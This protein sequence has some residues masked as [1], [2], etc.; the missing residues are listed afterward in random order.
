MSNVWNFPD[1]DYLE[2]YNA[3]VGIDDAKKT[4]IKITPLYAGTRRVEGLGQ[5][6]ISKASS[7]IDT[8]LARPPLIIISGDVGT[9]KTELATTIGAHVARFSKKPSH[10]TL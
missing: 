3:L 6:R 2:R 1:P 7:I 8:V 10:Y 4:A 9:G 5:K